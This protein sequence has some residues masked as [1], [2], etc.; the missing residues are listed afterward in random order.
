MKNIIHKNI[1]R[2]EFRHFGLKYLFCIYCLMILPFDLL[3]FVKGTVSAG[4]DDL[5]E[6]KVPQD[7]LT[8]STETT[9]QLKYQLWKSDITSSKKE[10]EQKY[11]SDLNRLIEQ[12][13][14]IEIASQQSSETKAIPET[15]PSIEPNHVSI[16]MSIPKEDAKDIEGIM[17]I[18]STYN[19]VQNKKMERIS[20]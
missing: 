5:V 13:R 15:F 10:K 9:K 1:E 14:S 12:V 6:Y 8:A 17:A 18:L 2:S 11:S 20:K 16:K 19:K 7:T 3:P 4:S